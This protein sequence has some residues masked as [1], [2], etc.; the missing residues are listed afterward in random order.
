MLIPDLFCRPSGDILALSGLSHH[1]EH[2]QNRENGFASGKPQRPMTVAAGGM[3]P[4]GAIVDPA[5]Y[6]LVGIMDIRGQ[7]W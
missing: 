7:E 1:F 6:T 4:E 5:M 2:R 3:P